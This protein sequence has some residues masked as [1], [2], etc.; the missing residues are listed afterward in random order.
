MTQEQIARTIDHIL[1]VSKA[2]ETFVALTATDMTSVACA[3][4]QLLPSSSSIDASVQ[5]TIHIG[6]RYASVTGNRLEPASLDALLRRAMDSAALL[7]EVQQSASFAEA[8]TSPVVPLLR[9]KNSAIPDAERLDALRGM[10][11]QSRA[12]DLLLN[13]RIATAESVTALASSRGLRLEQPASM[14][15][16]Q[17]RTLTR[18]GGSVGYAEDRGQQ[19]R[20]RTASL[21]ASSAITKCLAW[22]NPVELPPQRITTILDPA[23]LAELMLPT[24]RQ[25]D[26]QAIAENRSFLRKLDGSSSVGSELF[27]KGFD[28]LSDPL[29]PLAPSYPFTLDGTPVTKQFWVRNGVVE[30]VVRSRQD[31]WRSGGAIMPF[32]TNFLLNGSSESLDQIIASTQKGLLVCSLGSVM[33]ENPINGLLSAATRDGLF[34]VEDGKIRRGVQNMILMETGV[35][36]FRR[37]DRASVPVTVHPRSLFFPLY[38]PAIRVPE[39]LFSRQSGLI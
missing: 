32:P 5:V 13:G 20:P 33:L 25:F 15:H 22:R 10:I 9:Q 37:M 28:I 14:V 4:N 8:W 29:H 7:P 6:G 11:E 39:L 24:M 36:L 19:W 16:M 34:L 26:Q 17:V 38:L 27:P 30:T 31:S 23:A 18:D 35:G 1:S 3:S 21:I 2:D 12:A